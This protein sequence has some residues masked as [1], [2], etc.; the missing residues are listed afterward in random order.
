MTGRRVVVAK[1]RPM[2]ADEVA[3]ALQASTWERAQLRRLQRATLIRIA[4]RVVPEWSPVHV[5][6]AEGLSQAASSGVV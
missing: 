3:G 2:I 4:V 1:T 6:P 5:E